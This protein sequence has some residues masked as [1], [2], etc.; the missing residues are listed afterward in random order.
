MRT[1]GGSDPPLRSCYPL[2]SK[3]LLTKTGIGIINVPIHS[4]HLNI[5]V[6]RLDDVISMYLFVNITQ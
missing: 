5:Q 1:S 3:N 2:V 6:N 4:K